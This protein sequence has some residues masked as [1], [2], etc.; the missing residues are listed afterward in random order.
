VAR[1]IGVFM[2]ILVLGVG[3]GVFSYAVFE[4][5]G[6]ETA[7]TYFSGMTYFED[8]GSPAVIATPDIGAFTEKN[9][10]YPDEGKKTIKT[11]GEI[12]SDI[13][14]IIH[15]MLEMP[16]RL[17][18]WSFYSSDISVSAFQNAMDSFSSLSHETPAVWDKYAVY[19]AQLG[20]ID[21]YEM[22]IMREF[23]ESASGSYSNPLGADTYGISR[24]S[25]LEIKRRLV[26]QPGETDNIRFI[27]T[28][29]NIG[30]PFFKDKTKLAAIKLST[31]MLAPELAD[32]DGDG[33][34]DMA[35]GDWRG[36]I[37][38]F[39]NTGNT[40]DPY[41]VLYDSPTNSSDSNIFSDVYLTGGTAFGYGTSLSFADLDADGDYDLAIGNAEHRGL[42][43]YENTGTSADPAWQKANMFD[44]LNSTYIYGAD[45]ADFDND[46]DPDMIT[47]EYDLSDHY[48]SYYE[49]TGSA[50]APVWTFR[51]SDDFNLSITAAK[52]TDIDG[53]NDYDIVIKKEGSIYDDSGAG[54][55]ILENNGTVSSPSFRFA[56]DFTI[57][58]G[59]IMPAG[60]GF[61]YNGE[62]GIAA[63][64]LDGD[65][66][67]DLVLG[68]SNGTLTYYMN[69]NGKIEDIYFYEMPVLSLGY[70]D[71][72]GFYDIF[73]GT[74]SY[75]SASDTFIASM[76]VPGEPKASL[77]IYGDKASSKHG[78]QDYSWI[79]PWDIRF[80]GGPGQY[81]SL[82][83][84]GEDIF[85]TDGEL[86]GL[87]NY[88]VNTS[89]GVNYSCSS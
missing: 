65:G 24:N 83:Q 46:G 10:G 57:Y 51:W 67:D 15:R 45:F 6:M 29:K 19:S 23:D 20:V 59:E 78:I 22:E 5:G 44:I 33:D 75:D 64:D 72:R 36:K 50:S 34:L 11:G 9:E 54:V 27:Y 42:A 40:T 12:I 82:G 63:G 73:N 60:T 89:N 87:D 13:G 37:Y 71:Y 76:D 41:F 1:N 56:N 74:V 32:L 58:H 79:Y 84:L 35:V 61:F 3:L 4:L 28:L 14:N 66:D 81:Y 70:N 55:K 80:N 7:A 77:L 30:G 39:R 2:L 31:Y 18:F 88:K 62:P 69:G 38:Y 25:Q 26:M 86:N 43:Y 68:K 21:S 49:N 85:W 47:A 48:L 52:A 53:D 17:A 16:E 8:K